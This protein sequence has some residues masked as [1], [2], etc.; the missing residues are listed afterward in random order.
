MEKSRRFRMVN[1][2]KKF[3]EIEHTEIE[4][5]ETDIPDDKI[6]WCSVLLS[7]VL[8]NY[9]RFEASAYSLEAKNARE[10]INNSKYPSKKLYGNN[11]FSDTAFYPGRFKRTYISN[12]ERSIGFLGSSEMLEINPKP[13]KYLN[14]EQEDLKSLFVKR[15]DVLLSRSGTIGNI[16]YVSKTLQNFLVSEHSIRLRNIE[17]S[18]YIYAFLK[19]PIGQCLIKTN[20]FGS[21]VSQIEPKHLEN[22]EIPNPPEILKKEIHNLIVKSYDLRDESNDLIDEAEKLLIQ[23]LKLPPIEDFKPKYYN[24]NNE[25]RNFEVSLSKLNNRFD[26]SYHVP[27]VDCIVEHLKAHSKALK[28]IGDED[29]SAEVILPGRFARTYVEEGQGTLFF[30]GKQINELE[31]SVKKYLSLALHNKRIE[32]ELKLQENM[33]LITRSGTIGRVNIVPHHWENWIINEHVIRVKPKNTDIA[34]YLYCWLNSDYGKVL[35]ERYTY[36][37]VVNEI[38][39]NHV[40]NIDIPIIKS[41]EILRQINNLILQANKKRYEAYILEQKAIKMV[42]EKVIYAN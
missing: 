30:G 8:N 9:N 21:V 23:E 22:I 35:I 2:K 32:N 11:G 42:N 18:G 39:T 16:A 1:T 41:H 29:I 37:S 13:V 34:G 6:N 31:P 12:G 3:E 28:K 38:D 27:I 24:Q 5:P 40:C 25:I 7:E 19:T 26:A 33:V 4:V 20:T 36:G 14:K 10:E 15:G 17:Y